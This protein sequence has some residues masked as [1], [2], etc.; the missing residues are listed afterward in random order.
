MKDEKWETQQK[1]KEKMLSAD[2]KPAFPLRH[3][4]TVSTSQSPNCL[5][6]LRYGQG[7]AGRVDEITLP[8]LCISFVTTLFH[9]IFHYLQSSI[10]DYYF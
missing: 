9:K 10:S 1:S 2:A 6:E 8:K 3:D 4:N 7:Y 5:R